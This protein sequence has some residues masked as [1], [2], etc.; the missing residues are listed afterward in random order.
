MAKFTDE[1]RRRLATGWDPRVCTLREYALQNGV[2]ERA[3]RGWRAQLRR[4]EVSVVPGG[5]A[6][7]P[8][9]ATVDALQARLEDLQAAVDA[10]QANVAAVRAVLDTAAARLGVPAGTVTPEPTVVERKPMPRNGFFWG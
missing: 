3:I 9:Q 10:L 5:N 8:P 6:A 1:T 7:V 2:S 4:E